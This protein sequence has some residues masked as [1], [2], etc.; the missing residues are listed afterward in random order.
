MFDIVNLY[1]HVRLCFYQQVNYVEAEY[2]PT[3]TLR[4]FV[5]LKLKGEGF[6]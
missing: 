3:L 4:H 6:K 2:F 5:N 1:F